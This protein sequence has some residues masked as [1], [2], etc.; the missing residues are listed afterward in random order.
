MQAISWSDLHQTPL[1]NSFVKAIYTA[2][3]KAQDKYAYSLLKDSYLIHQDHL[4]HFGTNPNRLFIE[5]I[6]TD[7]FMPCVQNFF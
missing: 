3:P 6:K 1:C 5:L 7:T 2:H 4:L